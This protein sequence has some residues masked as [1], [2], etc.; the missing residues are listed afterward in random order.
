MTYVK[1]WGS[2]SGVISSPRGLLAMA[3]DSFGCR[4][5]EGRRC[6]WHLVSRGQG[7]CY[8]SYNT[9]DDTPQQSII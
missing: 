8:I 2:Q 9:Q 7:C 4:N 6:Y 5:V 3:G 1:H